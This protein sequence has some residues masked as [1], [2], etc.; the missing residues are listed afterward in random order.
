MRKLDISNLS[1][2]QLISLDACTSCSECVAWCPVYAQDSRYDLTPRAKI[3]A[4]KKILQGQYGLK[5]AILGETG[6]VEKALGAGA[7]RFLAKAF[8]YQ[9]LDQAAIDDFVKNVYECST[10]GQCHMVC[11]AG[12]DTVNIW[13]SIRRSLVTSGQGPLPNHKLLIQSTISYDNPWG[14]PRSSRARW[15]RTGKKEKLLTG[16]VKTFQKGMPILLFVGCTASYDANVKEVAM[17]VSNVLNALGLDWGILGTNEKCCGSVLLRMGDKE[18]ERIAGQNI[19][20]FNSLGIQYLVTSCSGCFKTI[21]ED[22]AKVGKLNFEVLHVAQFLS[23]MM[24]EGR[25]QF[26]KALDMKVTYHDPCHLGRASGVYAEPR[27]IIKSL[28]GVELVEMERIYHNSRCCGAGGGLKAGY[29]EI[30]QKM[31]IERIQ[32]AERTGATELVSACPFCYQGLQIGITALKSPI[33]MRDLTELVALAMGLPS[34]RKSADGE[35]QP[36]RGEVRHTA[37]HRAG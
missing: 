18:F 6:L 16:D 27:H 24:A 1:A 35:A 15:V 4:L 7:R 26:K 13:E 10:C 20:Q 34:L 28:P 9:D 11:P 2:L 32:E 25:V 14:Q 30:Q 33:V 36:D 17:N 22:Y 8:R 3:T 29:P 19:E 31:T 5:S 23:R 21:S 12:I 37:S